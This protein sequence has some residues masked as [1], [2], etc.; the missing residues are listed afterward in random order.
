MSPEELE[1]GNGVSLE[2]C[3]KESSSESMSRFIKQFMAGQDWSKMGVSR[4]LR[5]DGT[6]C[7]LCKSHLSES[8]GS[9]L[10]SQLLASPSTNSLSSGSS[11][12][13]TNQLPDL[14]NSH[15]QK[16]ISSIADSLDDWSGEKWS[17][18]IF[19]NGSAS[20]EH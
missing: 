13:A 19:I 7:W 6:L 16:A 5:L 8:K 15:K 18:S 12:S 14:P 2:Q 17:G 10:Q 20:Q 9:L 4:D 3:W 1:I 11:P